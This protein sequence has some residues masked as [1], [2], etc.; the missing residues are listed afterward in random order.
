MARKYSAQV[1]TNTT[2]TTTTE[3]VVATLSGLSTRDPGEVVTVTGTVQFTVGTG[4]TAVT[5]R[6]RRG[7]TASGTVVGEG[8]PV[9]ATAADTVSVTIQADDVPGEVAGQS[10]VLTVTQTA[11]TGDGSALFAAVDALVG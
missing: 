1:T 5:P 3:T 6:I 4:G 10:Y 11:A 2:V 7:S 8:N 9:S